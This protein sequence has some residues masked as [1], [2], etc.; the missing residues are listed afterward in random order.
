[1]NLQ[2]LEGMQCVLPALQQRRRRIQLLILKHGLPDAKIADLL[3]EAERQKIPVQR[4]LKPEIDA[5]AYGRTH[6]GVLALCSA[7]PPG[8]M[9]ELHQLIETQASATLL[10]LLEGVEDT[11]NLGYTMR[12][13]EALGVQAILLKK[14]LWDFDETAVSR[15]SSGAYERLPLIK[16]ERGAEELK[17]LQKRGLKIW[18]CLANAKRTCYDMDLTQPCVLAIGGEKRG[19][20]GAVRDRCDGF[21]KIPMRQGAS[22]LSLSHAAC[23][24]MGEAMRQRRV[25]SPSIAE[26]KEN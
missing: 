8:S 10:L 20:S 17:G 14:H 7:K 19:L 18:G 4:L 23:I 12:S 24:L 16:I 2:R 9:D 1:L 21:M 13:A 5:M 15:S 11:Q 26:N 3:L 25:L 22:S 6:G